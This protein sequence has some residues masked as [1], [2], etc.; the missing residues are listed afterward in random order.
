[1]GP[2]NQ[3]IRKPNGASSRRNPHSSHVVRGTHATVTTGGEQQMKSPA[4]KKSKTT[5]MHHHHAP[6][7][8]NDWQ[9]SP[10]SSGESEYEED[11]SKG[12]DNQ[13]KLE[14]LV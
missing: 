5:I 11:E 2:R 6:T 4:K 10:C 3:Q 1:M 12:G 7:R 9:P 14:T 13:F 8:Y